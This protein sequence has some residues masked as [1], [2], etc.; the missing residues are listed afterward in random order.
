MQKQQAVALVKGQRPV[1]LLLH[2]HLEMRP[3]TPAHAQGRYLHTLI[4]QLLS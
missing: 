1:H 2:L 3:V 4:S